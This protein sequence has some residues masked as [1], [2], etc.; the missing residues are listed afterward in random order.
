[1]GKITFNNIDAKTEWGFILKAGAFAELL[2]PAGAWPDEERKL[3]IPGYILADNE[4][5]FWKKYHA[6]VAFLSSAQTFVLY[7]EDLHRR[8]RL[9]Y[10]SIGNFDFLGYL[11]G[12]SGFQIVLNAIDD[13]PRIYTASKS[14][15]FTPTQGGTPVTFTRIYSSYTQA[16]ATAL[17]AADTSFATDGQAFANANPITIPLPDFMSISFPYTFPAALK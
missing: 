1:M 11:Q 13:Y 6:F 15:P 9:N 10:D 12:R 7:V 4:V 17:M 3:S 8:F 5:D 2:K 14:Q 16:D